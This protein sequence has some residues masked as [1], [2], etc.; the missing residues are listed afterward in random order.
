MNRLS[1]LIQAMDSGSK[2]RLA[3]ALSI[4][5]ILLGFWFSNSN[6]PK[7]E[8]SRVVVNEVLA[9]TTFMVHVAGA[10]ANPG[11]YELEAGARVSDAVGLAGGFTDQALESSVNLARLVSDGEQIV[12]LDSSQIEASGG[13]VSL[14]SAS[15][16]KLEELPGI[17]PATAK[18]IVDYRTR[19]GSF[20]SIEQ[21]TEVAGIGNKL[22]ERIRD[23]LTL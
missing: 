8:E 23:Q 18:K 17:G 9:P 2:R 4:A 22:L 16:E 11:L 7:V 5:A 1:E 3:I 10:V 19:I 12:V 6:A 14:N 15:A 21:L 13:F 20:S